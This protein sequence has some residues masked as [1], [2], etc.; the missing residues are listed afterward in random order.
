MVLHLHKNQAGVTVATL[1]RSLRSVQTNG[2]GSKQCRWR[3]Y[4]GSFFTCCSSA[5]RSRSSCSIIFLGVPTMSCSN[6]SF[7]R[8]CRY[9]LKF[10]N[11][12]VDIPHGK[13]SWRF[14]PSLMWKGNAPMFCT[15]RPERPS[16]LVG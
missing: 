2:T 6:I 11:P 9:P 14:A 13:C 12:I 3:H 7:R 5:S 4:F 8:G 10:E 15:F 16:G 1:S